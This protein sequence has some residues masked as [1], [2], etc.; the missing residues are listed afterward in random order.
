MIEDIEEL[1]SRIDDLE[2]EANDLTES[3]DNQART[4]EALNAEIAGTHAIVGLVMS[5]LTES[6][7]DRAE[8]MMD[9]ALAGWLR[10]RLSLQIRG[11]IPPD[12]LDETPEA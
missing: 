6:R 2:G 10:A 1:Q 9:E 12:D 5:A 7:R 11:V 3:I 8:K 4:I